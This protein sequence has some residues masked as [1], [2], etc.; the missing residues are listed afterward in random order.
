MMRL[1]P[2]DLPDLAAAA[3]ML[4]MP[5]ASDA[6]LREAE[7]SSEQSAKPADKLVATL[8]VVKEAIA[9]PSTRA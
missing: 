7:D 2:G 4:D 3:G 1:G 6:E 5:K 8:N 9:N